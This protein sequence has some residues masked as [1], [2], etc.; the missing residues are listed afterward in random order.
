MSEAASC[1]LEM[2]NYDMVSHAWLLQCVASENRS[3]LD[4]KEVLAEL[5]S[6]D[7]EVGEVRQRSPD[8][9]EFIAWKGTIDERV[10][11]GARERRQPDRPGPGICLLVGSAGERGSL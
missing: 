3:T 4:W 11:R 2:L 5:L 6:G 8:Y 10:S 7:V 1:V 9:L